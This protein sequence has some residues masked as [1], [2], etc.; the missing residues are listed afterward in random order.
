AKADAEAKAKADAE[1]KAKADAEAKA[2]A[3]AE[4]KAKAD[5]EAKLLATA[6]SRARA[7]TTTPTALSAPITRGSIPPTSTPGFL[8]PRPL[9]GSSAGAVASQAAAPL[10]EG[11]AL[12][13]RVAQLEVTANAARSIAS[14][15]A[16]QIAEAS[17]RA[18]DHAPRLSQLEQELN[19][20]RARSD[21]ELAEVRARAERPLSLEGVE[22]RV[23]SVAQGHESTRTVVQALRV[24]VD[25]HSRAFEA[26]KIRIDAIEHE[27]STLRGDHHL[28]ELRR[29]I[30]R[31]DLRM[32]AMEESVATLRADLAAR[33]VPPA[34][35]A[36]SAAPASAA[37]TS[38]PPAASAP[39]TEGIEAL[40]RIKGVGPKTAK[41][42]FEAGV[43]SLAHVAAWNEAEIARVAELL[44]KKPAQIQKAGWV[45][46]ARVLLESP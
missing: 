9:S 36:A 12:R 38:T 3:D 39:P 43:T 24:E 29:A 23:E 45:A 15:L 18:T 19:E 34:A 40:G 10:V 35:A 22:R 16:D 42:L 31:L 13:E 7:A 26:R 46:A 17:R 5:A 30:E 1:A 20:L 8:I 37:P 41:T 25:A 11:D 28:A 14:R 33:P 2:K 27:L 21:R 4:A 6:E 44:G 32:A